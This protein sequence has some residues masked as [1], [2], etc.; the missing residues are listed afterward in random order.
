MGSKAIKMK[1][2]NNNFVYPC[3]YYPVG[4][5]YLSVNNINPTNFFGGVWE[6]IKDTFL[7]ACGDTYSNGATG[8]SATHQH[9]YKLGYNAYFRAFAGTDNELLQIYNYETNS[10]Q[11]AVN[12]TSTHFTQQRNSGLNAGSIQN[13]SA[14]QK[15]VSGYTQNSSTLPPYLAVYMWKRTA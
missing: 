5:I 1:D 14:T 6:Q 13:F 11:N 7:L 15:S 2:S 10:W 3:P 9:L 12:D 8:G 4:S